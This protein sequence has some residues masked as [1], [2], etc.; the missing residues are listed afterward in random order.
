VPQH[1]VDPGN[2]Q[3]DGDISVILLPNAARSFGHVP[4]V[5]G[6]LPGDLIL[7]REIASDWV[8]SAIGRLQ[9]AAG[10][11]DEH[12]CWT[13]A[14]VFLYNDLVVEAVP[15]AGVRTRSIYDDVP[16]TVMRVRRHPRITDAERYT[17]AMGAL[18]SLG[19]RYSRIEALKI[20]WKMRGGLWNGSTAQLSG[21]GR[22]VI[23]SK[24]FADASLD[25]TRGLLRG[26]PVDGPITP[27]HL[28]ATT[29]LDDVRIGWLKLI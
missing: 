10:F 4:N 11:A 29:S 9:S 8:S 27:A 20:G 19:S 13:H 16:T 24:V 3:I 2:L 15:W 12:S 23:C 25:V 7:Y 17:I 22:T 5:R 21:I 14:A 28:S 26:C 1:T 18:K 6:C